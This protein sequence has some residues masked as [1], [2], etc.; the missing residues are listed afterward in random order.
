MIAQP[1][2]SILMVVKQLEL[3]LKSRVGRNRLA[4]VGAVHDQ[5]TAIAVID[6]RP[7]TV[8]ERIINERMRRHCQRQ[9][10]QRDDGAK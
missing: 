3:L 4:R 7:E 8:A 9:Q 1:A 2:G 5:I 6:D 10:G